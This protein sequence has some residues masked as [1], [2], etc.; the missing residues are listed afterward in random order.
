MLIELRTI[1]IE[2]LIPLGFVLVLRLHLLSIVKQWTRRQR[3]MKQIVTIKMNASRS[4]ILNRDIMFPLLVRMVCFE[5]R[6]GVFLRFGLSAGQI[7]RMET[8]E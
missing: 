3:P 2:S 4:L 5:D 8:A 6:H 1:N 7:D